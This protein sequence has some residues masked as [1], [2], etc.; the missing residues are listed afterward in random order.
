MKTG[1][2][3]KFASQWCGPYTILDKLS[4]TNYRIKLIGSPS[5]DMVVHHNW[6]KLCYGTPQQSIITPTPLNS[7]QPSYAEVVRHTESEPIGGYSSSSDNSSRD[8]TV[9]ATTRP[10]RN[11]GP[12]S[13]YSDFVPP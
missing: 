12:P 9:P 10:R 1:T 3:K 11:C 8:V 5:K 13:R 2:S 6:L 7:T 4:A